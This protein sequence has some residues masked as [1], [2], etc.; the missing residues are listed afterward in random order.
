MKRLSE[1]EIAKLIVLLAVLFGGWLRLMPVLQAGFP[2]NDGGMFYTMI[3]DL[4][5][6][7]FILPK[8]TS[9]N[10]VNIPY[11]YPPL[12]FYVGAALKVLFGIETLQILMFL[13]AALSTLSIWAFFEMARQFFSD[14]WPKAA[15]ATM[16]FAFL[17]RSYSWFVMGGGLTRSLGQVFLLLM[18]AASLRLYR[19]GQRR[20]IWLTGLLGGLVVLSHPEASIHGITAAALFWFFLARNRQGVIN[21]L[22]VAAIVGLVSAPWWATILLQH[23]PAPLL[24]ALQTGGHS[25][26]SFFESVAFIFAEEKLASV[27]TVLGMV[28]I[29]YQLTRGNFFLSAW[30]GLHFVTQP[31]SAKAAA[32]YPLALLSA[33]ALQEIILPVLEKG[34][35]VSSA[36]LTRRPAQMAVLALMIYALLSATVYDLELSNNH[37]SPAGY[38]AML[39]VRETTPTASQFLVLESEVDPALQK[40]AEW[41]PALAKRQSKLTLQGQEWVLGNR[42]SINFY[43]ETQQ[44]LYQEAGC[45]QKLTFDYVYLE[46]QQIE[47]QSS[48]YPL[49]YSLQRSAEYQMVYKNEK[50]SIFQRKLLP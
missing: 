6:N 23:G 17:P 41:F 24:S 21:S 50:V 14:S 42:F 46:N 48:P 43:A 16:A 18:L 19:R 12:A 47:Q 45:L 25:F 44:C 26:Y 30:L 11:A 20:D 15:L 13:P 31:R 38:V 39:W 5:A 33:V 35:K 34:A 28:G 4:A 7:H 40:S 32:I 36:W 3:E 8:F 27:I 1:T 49:F 22:K 37:L 29:L 2:I 9:Y 10:L